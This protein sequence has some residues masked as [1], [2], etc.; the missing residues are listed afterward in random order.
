M[1]CELLRLA[2]WE[3]SGLTE[4]NLRTSVAAHSL[5]TTILIIDY[6]LGFVF[7]LGHT[8]DGLGYSAL[9][10]KTLPDAALLIMQLGLKVDLLL[11]NLSLPGA[12]D[13]IA[14]V[15][16]GHHQVKVIGII[17]EVAPVTTLP[18][19]SITRLKPAAIDHPTRTCWIECV[20][21][22]LATGTAHGALP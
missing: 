11:I 20:E 3:K 13:F 7:W 19:V 14:A 15:H 17:E 18:G 1:D 21:N 9:P 5:R 2:A 16:R 10:A 22:V 8:L 12:A 6:D 4:S